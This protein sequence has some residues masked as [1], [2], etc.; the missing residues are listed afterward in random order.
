MRKMYL[1]LAATCVCT[2]VM[3]VSTVNAGVASTENELT[4]SKSSPSFNVLD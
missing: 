4:G 3:L 1:K 2:A